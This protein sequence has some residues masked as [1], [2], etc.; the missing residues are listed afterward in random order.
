[1]CHCQ[2]LLLAIAIIAGSLQPAS[3]IQF[4]LPR[5]KEL[6]FTGPALMKPQMHV[7]LEVSTTADE[8]IDVLLPDSPPFAW[9]TSHQVF[10][11]ILEKYGP[12]DEL[13]IVILDYDVDANM[14]VLLKPTAG[15]RCTISTKVKKA[16]PKSKNLPF[17]L[18]VPNRKRAPNKKGLDKSSGPAVKKLKH[19]DQPED[20]WKTLLQQLSPRNTSLPTVVSSSSSSSTC[21]EGEASG[22]DLCDTETEGVHEQELS[23]Y[24]VQQKEENATN[25]VLSSHYALRE[26]Q[27][28]QPEGSQSKRVETTCCNKTVGLISVTEQ[29]ANRLAQCRHCQSKIQ[30][31]MTR[32][33]YSYNT[34]KFEA[35]IHPTCFKSYLSQQVPGFRN[36]EFVC[37]CFCFHSVSL[38]Q[39]NIHKMIDSYNF[40]CKLITTY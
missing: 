13:T 35:Y 14:Q 24:P 26:Q 8:K 10:S 32:L 36:C 16:I 22:D 15:K 39:I 6:F 30:K 18:K 23:A 38:P 4:I 20:M 21:S 2:P 12:R 11:R 19:G 28:Q 3:L 34:K 40:D 29:K 9:W 27:L 25:Q 1:M 5:S 7:M 31:G 33:A 37:V 17:G